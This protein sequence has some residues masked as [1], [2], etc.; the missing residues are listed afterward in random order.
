MVRGI[1]SVSGYSYTKMDWPQVLVITAL[2]ST[3]LL[4][5]APIAYNHF[6]GSTSDSLE[7]VITVKSR[8]NPK[9]KLV[10]GNIESISCDICRVFVA[11]LRLLVSRQAPEE[12]IIAF[13]I[14]VCQKFN[15]EDDKVCKGVVYMFKVSI[16]LKV[17]KIYNLI[18]HKSKSSL[19]I[20]HKCHRCPGKQE[21]EV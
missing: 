15:I 11:G 8:L 5:G 14:E 16:R 21:V 19:S 3:F 12:D 4:S 9:I 7:K 17:K 13:S 6:F 1:T 18:Q 20:G 2:I 10:C